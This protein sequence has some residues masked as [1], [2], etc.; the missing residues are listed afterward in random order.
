MI[1]EPRL[2]I[3]PLHYVLS[4]LFI[5]EIYIEKRVCFEMVILQPINV[6]LISNT[7]DFITFFSLKTMYEI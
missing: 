6:G 4:V 7:T 3:E 2:K 1:N 5:F